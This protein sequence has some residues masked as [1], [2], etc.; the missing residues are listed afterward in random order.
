MVALFITTTEGCSFTHSGTTGVLT[1]PG[2]PSKY[3]D[4][5]DCTYRISG[6]TGKGIILTF[7]AFDVESSFQ[8]GYDYLEVVE[9]CSLGDPI[10][11]RKFCG[12]EPP[13][14]VISPCNAIKLTFHTDGSV[15]RTG[16][17]AEYRVF[18]RDCTNLTSPANGSLSTKIV[19]Y[20]TVVTVSCKANF[21]LVGE[22]SVICML[23]NWSGL[24]GTCEAGKNSP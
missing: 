11:V 6:I 18:E 3:S 8:C 9:E 22:H 1:S 14:P 5:S 13:T 4:D 17:R 24:I 15:S 10:I 16:F 7:S 21:T 19:K 2:Y 23:G 12:Y 20:G